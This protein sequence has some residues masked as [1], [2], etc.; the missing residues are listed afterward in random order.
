MFHT[1]ELNNQINSLHKKALRLTY[2]NINSSFNELLKIDKSVSIDYRNLQCLLSKIYKVK[3]GLSPPIM[4]DILTID[5]N[6][7]CNLRSDVT[8]TR[9]IT[10][11]S[12]SGFCTISAI[13]AVLWGTFPNYIKNSDSLNFFKHKIKQWTPD[14]CQCKICKNFT[15]KFGIHMKITLA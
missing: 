15:K 14:N 13:A 7:S 1:K 6:A 8:V 12:K 2:Q 5:Q 3:I 9:R 11:T 4:N 10:R